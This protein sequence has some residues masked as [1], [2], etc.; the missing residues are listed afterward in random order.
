MLAVEMRVLPRSAQM[1]ASLL[2]PTRCELDVL[3]QRVHHETAV[4]LA[5]G[6][7]AFHDRVLFDVGVWGNV[8]DVERR[9]QFDF[10]ADGATVA[11]EVVSCEIA[12]GSWPGSFEGWGT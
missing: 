7:V 12:G 6:A 3:H 1:H 9:V 5:V 8:R 4:A 11:V 10:V 2:L